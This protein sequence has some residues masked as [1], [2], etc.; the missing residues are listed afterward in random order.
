MKEISY[1]YVCFDLSWWKT[2][3]HS[4]HINCGGREINIGEV[5]Y[6]ADTEQKGASYYYSSPSEK[7]AFSSTGNFMDNDVDADIYIKSNTSALSNVSVIDSELYTT[8]RASA[9]SLTY[10]GLCLMNGNY[11]VKLHFAEIVF[12][13]DKTFNSLGKRIFDVYIQVNKSHYLQTKTW[14]YMIKYLI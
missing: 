2:E 11:T 1:K 6:E 12:T 4:L 3:H 5:K 9:I 8:A 7:W 10:Y 14:S 13:N